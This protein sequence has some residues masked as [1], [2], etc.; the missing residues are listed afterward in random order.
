VSEQPV[1]PTPWIEWFD[2]YQWNPFQ[3]VRGRGF[4]NAR[5][6]VFEGGFVV[7]PRWPRT[8]SWE[9]FEYRR[10]AVVFQRLLPMGTRGLLVE[11][12]GVLARCSIPRGQVARVR[13][14]LG[15]AGIDVID[16]SAWGWE[17]PRPVEPRLLGVHVGEVP[18]CVLRPDRHQPPE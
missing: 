12:R 1:P 17:E 2:V 9:Q 18:A 13:S 3:L 8:S 14:A 6:G 5:L 7:S 15:R 16:V 4:R 10:P 11:R